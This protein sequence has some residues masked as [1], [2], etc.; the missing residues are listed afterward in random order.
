MKEK[1]PILADELSRR[2]A[3]E[4]QGKGQPPVSEAIE[5]EAELAA[6]LINLAQDTHPD[7]DFVAALG[8]QLARR[9][10]QKNKSQRNQAPPERPSFWQ[11]LTQMLKEGTTMN[12]N[13]YLL[14]A[15]GALVLIVVAA[16]LVM[17]RDN[18]GGTEPGVSVAEDSST[19]SVTEDASNDNTE[20]ETEGIEVADLP[21]LPALEGSG[22]AQGLGGGGGANVRPQ[23]GGGGIAAEDAAIGVDGSFI[24]TDPFSGTTFTLNTTL[25]TEPLLST[26]L[27]NV[28]DTA[29]TV[30]KARELAAQFGFSGQ[31]YREQYPVFEGEFV[32][33]N[34]QPPVVYHI[35]D[36]PRSLIIDAWGAYYNDTSIENDW[37]NPISFEQAVPIA[38][39]YVQERGLLD[40]EYEIQQL[41]GSD[42]NFVRVI[43]GQPVN[44]P[45][46]TVGVSHDGRIF[47]ISYQVL[48]NAQRLGRYPLITAQAAWERLQSGVFENGILYNYSAGPETAVAEPAIAIEPDPN[49]DLYQFW[50]REYEPG[51]EIHLYDWPI[52]F[53]PVDG[54]ADPRIQ[55]RNYLVQA[56]SA[57]L[58]ALAER[59]GQQTHIWGQ[60][61]PEGTT[62]ELAGWEAVEENREP[63]AGPGIIS[64][65]GDQVLFTSN[66]SGN[67]YILP[68]AP[69]DLE[70]GLEVHLFAWAARDL[71]QA[72]PV[73]DWENIDK[74]VNI[75]PEILPGEE[76]PIE[77]PITDEP[78]PIDGDGRGFVPFTYES[79]TVNEVSL[80]YYYTYSWPTDDAGEIRYEGQPTIIVQPTWKFS[81]QTDTGEYVDFYVQATE[82]EHVER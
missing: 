27:Q 36:G 53:L 55:I 80:A 21:P 29:V 22:Q 13:K 56:D 19:P 81:G 59:V 69:A 6:K 4:M 77:E 3:A 46:L 25:P 70:D 76:L 79:F 67:I 37:D 28:P 68:D 72:H 51:E 30:E 18:F 39:A 78:L 58:N 74:I 2:I 42:V 14:G 71:G 63:I 11:Q 10:A 7:P 66:E 57:T 32:D 35:F 1:D 20:D 52:V 41:W 64:R 5:K 40:F 44:Q 33:P 47:F 24:Y 34:Y 60:V 9:A 62:I 75:E 61:G 45:E 8:S 31:L 54:G 12:R 48:R 65:E 82:A 16:Y 49:A 50:V 38:E 15:L 73:A 43:D 23:S 17:N 26:V